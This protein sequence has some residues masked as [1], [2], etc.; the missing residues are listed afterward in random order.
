MIHKEV[1]EEGTQPSFPFLSGAISSPICTRYF[2]RIQVK[3]YFP[4]IRNPWSQYRPTDMIDFRVAPMEPS[5][6]RNLL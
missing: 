3:I 4:F 1:F 5:S 2:A 6:F